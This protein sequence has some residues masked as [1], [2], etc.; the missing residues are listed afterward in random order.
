LIKN[1][2]LKHL[3]SNYFK[4]LFNSEPEPS[5]DAYKKSRLDFYDHIPQ[6]KPEWSVKYRRILKEAVIKD[7]IRLLKLPFTQRIAFL[8]DKV[9]RLNISMEATK[10]TLKEIKLILKETHIKCKEI[11]E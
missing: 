6:L 3:R 11:D 7:A 5:I 10:K 9:H 8:E 4:D 1:D 2:F